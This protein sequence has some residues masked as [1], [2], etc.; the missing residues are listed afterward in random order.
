MVA[1]QLKRAKELHKLSLTILSF[2][3]DSL[4]SFLPK[5]IEVI[6][7]A[8]MHLG[9]ASLVTLSPLLKVTNTLHSQ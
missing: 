1:K 4:L 9:R 5:R 6:S 3:V 2:G 8:K 7:T